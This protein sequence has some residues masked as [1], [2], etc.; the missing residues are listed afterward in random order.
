MQRLRTVREAWVPSSN[1]PAPPTLS[2]WS[3]PAGST[4]RRE[5]SPSLKYTRI[6]LLIN[7]LDGLALMY[8][9]EASKPW[10]PFTRTSPS[11]CVKFGLVPW[12]P[13]QR[14]S[15]QVAYFNRSTDTQASCGMGANSEASVVGNGSTR[16]QLQ[17]AVLAN[18]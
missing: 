15:K 18:F 13:V 4:R 6:E 2:T 3:R 10:K 12:W 11:P 14:S 7:Q 9:M 17:S 16:R 8:L 5:R 1:F